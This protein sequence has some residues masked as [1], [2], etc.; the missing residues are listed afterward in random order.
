MYFGVDLGG[1]KIELIVIDD[2]SQEYYRKRISTP[3]GDYQATLDAITSLVL[4]AENQLKV[5]AVVG[6][7]APGAVSQQTGRMKNCNSVWLNNRPLKTDLQ[8]QLQRPVQLANDANCFALSE[9]TDGA[10]QGANSV[11]GVILGTGVGAGL[12]SNGAIVNGANGICGEWGHNP[13][14]WPRSDELPG[15]RCYCG[16]SGCIETWLSGPG[17]SLDYSLSLSGQQVSSQD[18]SQLSAEQIIQLASQGNR[19]CTLSLKRYI[20]RLARG[21]AHV[22]NIIDPEVIVLGGG[23]S[24][25]EVLYREVPQQWSKYVFSDQVVT[26]LVAPRYGDSSGVRG[27]AWLAAAIAQY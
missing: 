27:A 1:T 15:R 7:G 6:I 18:A 21:L 25:C 2:D 10:G 23:L 9:A 19:A 13:L 4:D 3:K 14:P 24:N 16:Q 26:Q 5:K 20:D 8:H 12:V 17:F 22:I 11:F